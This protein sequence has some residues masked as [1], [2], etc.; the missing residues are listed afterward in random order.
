M[1]R[2]SLIELAMEYR[3]KYD[4]WIDTNSPGR[5]ELVLADLGANLAEAVLFYLS[6]ED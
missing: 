3:Q 4:E 6:I 5:A 1:S 2:D